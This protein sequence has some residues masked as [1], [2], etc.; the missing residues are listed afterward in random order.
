VKTAE[1]GLGTLGDGKQDRFEWHL[2]F[3]NPLRATAID[4]KGLSCQTGGVNTNLTHWQGGQD[5]VF[6]SSRGCQ[7][8]A[9]T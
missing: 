5:A 9:W 3:R 7:G 1:P 8:A 2:K 4:R 6:I